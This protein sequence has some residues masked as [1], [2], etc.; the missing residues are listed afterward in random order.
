MIFTAERME[1]R[2]KHLKEMC[3]ILGLDQLGAD[4]LH[5]P[6]PWEFLINHNYSLVWCNVF[7]SASTSWMFNFL[8]LAG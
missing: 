3:T 4:R 6:N 5:K 2:R 8:V 7:K 1:L